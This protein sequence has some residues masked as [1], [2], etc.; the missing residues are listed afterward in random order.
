MIRSAAKRSA[1]VGG[2]I[3]LGL[4]ITTFVTLVCAALAGCGGSLRPRLVPLGPSKAAYIKRANALCRAQ[5]RTFPW[6]PLLY[7]TLGRGVEVAQIGQA[8]FRGTLRELTELRDLPEP[9]AD[10][11][12]LAA[13]WAARREQ[14]IDSVANSNLIQTAINK[15]GSDNWWMGFQNYPEKRITALGLASFNAATRYTKLA[16]EFGISPCAVLQP[17]AKGSTTLTISR[18]TAKA[19]NKDIAAIAG[20][21]AFAEK[22][23]QKH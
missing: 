2:S 20:L 13:V 22:P 7:Q 8:T 15:L 19:L 23:R 10:R 14:L 9:R 11:E 6:H 5:E 17:T 1:R 3:R 4:W 16:N 12:Y 21:D 18:A